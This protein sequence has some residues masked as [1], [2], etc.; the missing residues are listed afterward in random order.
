VLISNAPI[1]AACTSGSLSLAY[2][3]KHGRRLH[4][5]GC[6]LSAVDATGS[7]LCR[8]ARAAHAQQQEAG[9]LCLRLDDTLVV[10][11]RK[12]AVQRDREGGLY[13]APFYDVRT[14]LP[15]DEVRN[16]DMLEQGRIAHD[17]VVSWFDDR[18]PD[19]IETLAEQILL[20][21]RR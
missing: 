19:R 8:R 11:S 18:D 10:G 16:P 20:R 6:D 4:E 21:P 2:V 14:V 17:A 7:R 5:R 13:D 12:D 1:P 3:S 15:A 9:E